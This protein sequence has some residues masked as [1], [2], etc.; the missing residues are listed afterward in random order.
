MD[1]TEEVGLGTNP[2]KLKSVSK[3][4]ICTHVYCHVVHNSK[5]WKQPQ[6]QLRD[7][8]IKKM[9]SKYKVG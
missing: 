8:W 2:N 5:M 7:E 6:C 4:N 1:P 3:S 9:W